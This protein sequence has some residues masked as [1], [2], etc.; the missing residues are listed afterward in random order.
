MV[1]KN[2]IAT[3]LNCVLTRLLAKYFLPHLNNL[4]FRLSF[5]KAIEKV[6]I[7]LSQA[8]F[9]GYHLSIGLR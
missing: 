2:D 3:K 8:H 5:K 1:V 7:D 4:R 9:F 6:K